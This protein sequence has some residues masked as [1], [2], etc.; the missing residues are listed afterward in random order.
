[1]TARVFIG[2]KYDAGT[3]LAEWGSC[4]DNLRQDPESVPQ[5]V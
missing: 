2:K 5:N 3:T 4:T 1:M